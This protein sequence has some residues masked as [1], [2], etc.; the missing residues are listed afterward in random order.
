MA[1]TGEKVEGVLSGIINPIAGKTSTTK[2]KTSPSNTG[3]GT[4]AIVALSL[5]GVAVII[6]LVYILK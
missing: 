6:G 2:T 5:I 1:S 4:A 3:V